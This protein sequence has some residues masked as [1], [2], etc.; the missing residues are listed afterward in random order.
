MGYFDSEYASVQNNEN[1]R[2]PSP[3]LE[4][5]YNLPFSPW[6]I[7]AMSLFSIY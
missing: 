7:N 6:L 2:V 3:L 4:S 5:L 1:D